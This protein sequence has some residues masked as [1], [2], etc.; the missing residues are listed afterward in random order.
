MP[1]TFVSLADAARDLGVA[2]STL[3]HQI[4]LRKLHATKIGRGWFVTPEAVTLYRERH[5]RMV[6]A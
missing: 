5:L 3:R 4:R 6:T 1:M 2:P